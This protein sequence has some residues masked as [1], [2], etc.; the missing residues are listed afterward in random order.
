MF[1]TFL[2]VLVLLGRRISRLKMALGGFTCSSFLV[3]CEMEGTL[4]GGVTHSCLVVDGLGGY[5]FIVDVSKPTIRTLT[6]IS[7][8]H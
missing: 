5:D 2:L 8:F 3:L 1:F 6:R 7:K 4:P